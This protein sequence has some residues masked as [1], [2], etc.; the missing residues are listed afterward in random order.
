MGKNK[1]RKNTL[2]DKY[3]Q[4]YKHRVYLPIREEV[5]ADFDF[6]GPKHPYFLVR[7]MTIGELD[8]LGSG[9]LD[10]MSEVLGNTVLSV[11]GDQSLAAVLSG[12]M[13]PLPARGKKRA[14]IFAS[15]L[16]ITGLDPL[17]TAIAEAVM[18]SDAEGNS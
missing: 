15:H 13:P 8:D 2:A 18:P 12:P 10:R 9:Q 7:S 14:K 6:E 17:A 4:K 1:P 5:G 16:L 3:L 11:G